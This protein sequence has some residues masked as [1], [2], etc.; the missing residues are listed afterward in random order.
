MNLAA[1]RRFTERTKRDRCELC[2]ADLIA[3]HE[4][5]VEPLKGK[6]I[7]ACGACAILFDAP[8]G[9]RYRR[10]PRDSEFLTGFQMSD[11]L[12]DKFEIP[13][14]L[15]FFLKSTLANKVVAFYPSPA[16]PVESLLVLDAWQELAATNPVIEAIEPDV[17][18]LLINRVKGARQCFRAPIDKCYGL[19]GL[20]R[21]H[22]RGFSGGTEVWDA[23]AAFFDELKRTSVVQTHD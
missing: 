12:W 20:I 2:G 17:E 11:A 1:L 3:E 14:G 6:M 23:V 19:C 15:A 16:G 18:A 5:L 4:H 7:C 10:V 22:W 21:M 8:A 13:I 9:N